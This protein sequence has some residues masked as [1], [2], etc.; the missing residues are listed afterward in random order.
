MSNERCSDCALTQ[1]TVLKPVENVNSTVHVP[2]QYDPLDA[3]TFM[4]PPDLPAHSVTIEFCDRVSMLHSMIILWWKSNLLSWYASAD[5]KHVLEPV[6]LLLVSSD[7]VS[8][9]FIVHLG[10]AQNYCWP[11]LHHCWK[12]LTWFP[13]TQTI[14]QADFEYGFPRSKDKL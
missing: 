8:V 9:G 10:S 4:H 2:S 12:E 3:S 5:G 1:D 6:I 13:W 11:S 14:L 7:L